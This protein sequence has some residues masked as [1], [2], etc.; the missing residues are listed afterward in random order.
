MLKRWKDIENAQKTLIKDC[1]DKKNQTNKIDTKPSNV[2]NYLKSLSQEAKDL[3]DE[4]EDAN[5]DIDI[6]KLAF[7]GSN[8]EN[9]NLNTFRMP[10]DFISVIHNGEISLKETKCFQKNLEDKIKEL[11]FNYESKDEKEKKEINGVLM[12]ANDL[13]EYRDKI[14]NAFKNGTFSSEYL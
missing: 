11:R 13:L 4:I 14:I 9:F 8:K 1:K 12:Q 6:Y 5:D 7:I 10:L 2:F 3:I